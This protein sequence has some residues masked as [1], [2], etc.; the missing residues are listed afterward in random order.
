M[1]DRCSLAQ[2]M[3]LIGVPRNQLARWAYWADKKSSYRAGVVSPKDAR[4]YRYYG[5][6]QMSD[7]YWC[8]SIYHPNAPNHCNVRCDDLL[9][10]DI[11]AAV[12]CALH[13]HSLEGFN[14]WGWNV[15]Y[16]DPESI[17]DCFDEVGLSSRAKLAIAVYSSNRI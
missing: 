2:E 13:V 10:D 14:P 3:R 6:F 8:K 9:S 11:T 1:L 7:R 12:K 5:L 16:P 15:V 4:G 17:D